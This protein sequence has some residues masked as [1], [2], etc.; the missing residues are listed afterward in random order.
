MD[1]GF[2]TTVINFFEKVQRIERK[3][4][5]SLPFFPRK[6]KQI[7]QKTLKISEEIVFLRNEKKTNL[8]RV[9]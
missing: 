1:F 8:V 6:V 5:V 2:V 3:H 7:I 4:F 9:T